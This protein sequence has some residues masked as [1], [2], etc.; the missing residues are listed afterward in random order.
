M[1]EK[2]CINLV[3]VVRMISRTLFYLK[4][5]L[6]SFSFVFEGVEWPENEIRSSHLDFA[7]GFNRAAP[8][9]MRNFTYS[10]FKD[11]LDSQRSSLVDSDAYALSQMESTCSDN[12]V[13]YGATIGW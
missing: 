8:S 13:F 2:Q 6:Y 7:L 3:E 1:V 12:G 9:V 10:Y 4:L 11:V 5:L